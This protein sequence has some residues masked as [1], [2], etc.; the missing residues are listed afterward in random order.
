MKRTHIHIGVSDLNAAITRY[1]ALFGAAPVLAKDDY[2]KWMLDNPQLN[3]AISSREAPGEVSHLGLQL[4][5][6]DALDSLA[7]DLRAAGAP[8]SAERGAHCCYAR[9]DKEWTE[10]ADGIA[11]EL[12]VTHEQNEAFGKDRDPAS[13]GIDSAKTSACCGPD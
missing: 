13:P 3:F 7:G 8:L 12:F 9:S 6:E 4:D 11:W 2:A 10:D 5:D 1:S